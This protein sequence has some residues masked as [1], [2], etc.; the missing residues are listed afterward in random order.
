MVD[1]LL[2]GGG[3][4]APLIIERLHWILGEEG[5]RPVVVWGDQADFQTAADPLSSRADASGTAYDVVIEST[6]QKLLEKRSS[7]ESSPEEWLPLAPLLQQLVQGAELHAAVRVSLQETFSLKERLR[8]SWSR[9]LM[10]NP[11]ENSPFKQ[12]PGTEMALVGGWEELLRA[13][14][15]K[16]A[17]QRHPLHALSSI[18]PLAE[19]DLAAHGAKGWRVDAELAPG[20]VRKIEARAVVLLGDC[21]GEFASISEENGFWRWPLPAGEGWSGERFLP[22]IHKAEEIASHVASLL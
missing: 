16:H 13:L 9:F 21:A 18:A 1:L 5:R 12:P 6:Q 19:S 20:S 11:D 4:Q 2:I 14:E 22:L 17:Q 7:S 15:V 3:L 10:R 8:R